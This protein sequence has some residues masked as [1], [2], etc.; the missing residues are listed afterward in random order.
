MNSRLSANARGAA[1]RKLLAPAP[2]SAR[3]SS[4]NDR[5]RPS[6]R[7]SQRLNSHE[8]A[9]F[10]EVE[11]DRNQPS[12]SWTGKRS[13]DFYRRALPKTASQADSAGFGFRSTS[14]RPSDAN[15]AALGGSPNEAMSRSAYVIWNQPIAPAR[16]SS[17]ASRSMYRPSYVARSG[18]PPGGNWTRLDL[19]PMNSSD[20]RICSSRVAC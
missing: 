9:Q 8:A 4:L 20:A 18:L 14:T 6:F 3:S 16:S 10:Q 13:G 7:P 11:I 12:A 5:E 2:T 1:R 17:A 15:G 19:R